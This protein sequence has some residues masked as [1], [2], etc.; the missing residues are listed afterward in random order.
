M[1][2]KAPL[3]AVLGA[4][5]L[6]LAAG[7]ATTPCTVAPGPPSLP[8]VPSDWQATVRSNCLSNVGRLGRWAGRETKLGPNDVPGQGYVPVALDSIGTGS[9][10]VD[11]RV[12]VHG[13]APGYLSAVQA[14]GRRIVWWGQNASVGGVWTSNW[15]WIPTS[16]S[17]FQVTDNGLFQQMQAENPQAWVLGFSWIDDSATPPLSGEFGFDAED[18]YQSEAHTNVAGIRLANALDQV[19]AP[20]FWQ[21][22]ANRLHLVGH[23]HGSKVVA[24]AAQLLQERHRADPK[25]GADHL[26]LLDSP[27]SE[28]TLEFGGANLVG[29]YLRELAVASDPTR[30]PPAGTIFVDNVVSYFGAA[31]REAGTSLDDVVQVLLYPFRLSISPEFGHSYSAEWYAGAVPGARSTSQ[32]PIGLAWPP[33]PTVYR[34][35]SATPF[36]D[37]A[38]FSSGQRTQTGQWGLA[39]SNAANAAR[40]VF[41]FGTGPAG[42]ARAGSS[43]GDVRFEGGRL[44]LGAGRGLARFH[45]SYDNPVDSDFYGL[46]FDLTWT[47][48][49]EGDYFVVTVSDSNVTTG[50]ETVLVIDGRSLAGA[51]TPGLDR[52]PVSFNSAVANGV[53]RDVQ[54]FVYYLPASGNTSG[55]I[56]LENFVLIE[57][58]AI[59][60][61]DEGP[62]P[63]AGAVNDG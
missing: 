50:Q 9:A 42:V 49:A 12:L 11:V 18:V 59:N 30:P 51:P 1:A 26:T 33:V 44:E 37:Q 17:G 53:F 57:S 61:R 21:N 3:Y 8:D 24:V 15:A 39:L 5:A 36:L 25:A 10:P 7:C 43:V 58:T 4:L 41:G 2:P 47:G 35:T 29:F 19:L 31:Y 14:A 16:V 23:S 62:V 27:E 46:G 48:A 54:F 13:W 38:W 32:P 34:P 6:L 52:V 63:G 22:P 20:A 45:G 60:D 40:A 28:S 55:R 56:T